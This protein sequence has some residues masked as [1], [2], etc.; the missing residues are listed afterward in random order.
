M[1]FPVIPEGDENQPGAILDNCGDCPPGLHSGDWRKHAVPTAGTVPLLAYAKLEVFHLKCGRKG[2]LYSLPF[3][4]VNVY[5]SL[6]QLVPFVACRCHTIAISLPSK[7]K[8]L[9]LV[10]HLNRQLGIPDDLFT[11]GDDVIL[12]VLGQIAFMPTL[13]L[14]ARLCPP[15]VEGTLFALLMSIFN[16]GAIVGSELGAFLT[17]AMGVTDS[18]FGNL[19][20][21]IAVCNLSTL[22]PL[23][24]LKWIEAVEADESSAD[25]LSAL[26]N[27]NGS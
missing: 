11:F 21:L 1:D 19:G 13:V 22:L 7:R 24:F 14:A 6:K 12:T 26:E 17:R 18:D 3:E 23:P 5:H 25:E 10:Y 20:M 15:G 2:R 27:D 8:Q 16:G 9:L 4:L